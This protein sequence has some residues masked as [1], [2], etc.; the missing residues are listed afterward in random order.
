MLRF[1]ND[2]RISVSP[3]RSSL[4]ILQLALPRVPSFVF[5]V[6]VSYSIIPTSPILSAFVFSVFLSLFRCVCYCITANYITIAGTLEISKL[7]FIQYE[8]TSI[9]KFRIRKKTN[10]LFSVSLLI[11]FP[12]RSER[13]KLLL[14]PPKADRKRRFGSYH[15]PKW[16]NF[17]FSYSELD[18]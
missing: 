5:Q 2:R 3:F 17:R 10:C 8:Y 14:F 6:Q 9:S 18:K 15:F 7:P 4:N 1:L 13:I 12:H 16:G 11:F